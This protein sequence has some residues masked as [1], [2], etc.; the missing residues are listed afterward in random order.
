VLIGICFLSVSGFSRPQGA[1]ESP[2]GKEGTQAEAN[3]CARRDFAKAEAE[4]NG[5]YEQ[6]MTELAGRAGEGRRKLEK[7]QSLWLQYREANCESEASVYEGGSIRPAVYDGCL[8][9]VTRERAG[10][11]RGLLAELPHR[12][13]SAPGLFT[14]Q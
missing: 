8:A 9:S 7:A 14:F 11:L 13:N 12:Y 1:G 3:A 5:V 10:R 2:C 6:L 4:M